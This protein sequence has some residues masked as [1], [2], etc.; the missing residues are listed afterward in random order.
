M[1][2][3]LAAEATRSANGAK[4]SETRLRISAYRVSRAASSSPAS[5]TVSLSETTPQGTL[6]QS[7][8]RGTRPPGSISTSSV[9]PPPMSKITAGP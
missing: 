2:S 4:L 8:I 6:A 7:M 1:S 5:G 3:A 9:D